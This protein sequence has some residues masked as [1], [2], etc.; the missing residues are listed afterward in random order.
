M[1]VINNLGVYANLLLQNLIS[2]QGTPLNTAV[3]FVPQ[4]LDILKNILMATFECLEITIVKTTIIRNL[5]WL[6]TKKL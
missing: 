5:V 2:R 6:L 1:E 4:V 3:M